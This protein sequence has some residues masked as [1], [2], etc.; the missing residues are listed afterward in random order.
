[1]DRLD[2]M[3]RDSLYTV[4]ITVKT[5]ATGPH[6][7][8]ARSADPGNVPAQVAGA[9]M[10]TGRPPQFR[11]RRPS[12][13][14]SAGDVVRAVRPMNCSSNQPAAKPPIAEVQLTGGF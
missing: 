10:P 14:F 7:G 12:A 2:A 11:Q 8:R 9:G 4:D 13:A 5:A 3:Q 1:M 6:A